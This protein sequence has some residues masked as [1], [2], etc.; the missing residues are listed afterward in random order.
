MGIRECLMFLEK[1][2]CEVRYAGW[3]SRWSF[4]ALFPKAVDTIFGRYFLHMMQEIELNSKV[5]SAHTY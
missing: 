1:D 4:L 5:L 2:S 3:A